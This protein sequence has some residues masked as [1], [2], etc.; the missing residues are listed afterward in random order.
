[1]SQPLVTIVVPNY[2]TLE[3]T[4][5]C[6]RLLRKY[7]DPKKA[8]VLVIDNDSQDESTDYLRQLQWIKLLERKIAPNKRGFIAH[9][10][11]LD[12]ALEHTTTPY[13]LSIHT[14]T[15]VKNSQWL[16]YLL[17]HIENQPNVAGVGSW[18]LENRPWQRRLAKAIERKI[19]IACYTLTNKQ[20]H[21]IEG[22]GKN[23]Y[24]L[25]THCAL[26]RTDLI[27][28]YQL[29]FSAEEQSPGKILNKSLLDNHHEL[30]FLPSKQLRNYLEHVDGATLVLNPQLGL[31]RKA[32][33]RG[34]KRI[35]R[36]LDMFDAERILVDTRLDN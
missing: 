15:L 23:F 31:N 7:T 33:T 30:V 9:G 16:D 1:M 28:Q 22:F 10:H 36:A 17:S 25:R 34:Q 6:L 32:I 27:R 24:Y 29:T 13:Y 8:E 21:N 5:L 4:K 35:K 14:D 26:F 18:K 20:D 12:L 2:K 3:L 19:Q 11:A